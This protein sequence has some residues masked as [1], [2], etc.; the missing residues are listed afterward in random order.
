MLVVLR[1]PVVD[2]SGDGNGS[3]FCISSRW[4]GSLPTVTCLCCPIRGTQRA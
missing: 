4:M 2:E 1:E 3:Q